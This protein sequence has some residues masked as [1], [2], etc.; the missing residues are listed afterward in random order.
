RIFGVEDEAE[1]LI[2]K[3]A[4]QKQA[5]VDAVSGLDAPSVVYYQG[6]EGPIHVLAGGIYTSAI[7]TAGG[8]SAF[9][10]EADVSREDF[11]A[12][13]AEVLLVATF[14]G[15]DFASRLAYLEETFPDLPAV[16]NGRVY[17]LPVADTDASISVMRGLTE[18]ANAI[19]G[20]D[21]PVPSSC[22]RARV[23]RRR[24]AGASPRSSW[25]S[26]WSPLS[27]SRSPWG[28]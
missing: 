9:P 11:A 7:E 3:L 23:W 19:H 10:T 8:T 27:C 12:S 18:I 2:A 1:A 21:L 25:S 26:R 24:L 5:V 17:E 28:R 22:P 6:G 20:L 13:D 14:E 16:K 4:A 15:Q